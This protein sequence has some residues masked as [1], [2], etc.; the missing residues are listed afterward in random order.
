M[1]EYT[2]SNIVHMY[3][4]II[5][6]DIIYYVNDFFLIIAIFILRFITALS[7]TENIFFCF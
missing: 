2:Y 1:Y 6:Q 5:N 3:I 7:R 4:F